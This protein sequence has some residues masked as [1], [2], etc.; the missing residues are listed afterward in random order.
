MSH[1]ILL[2]RK[3]V[4]LGQTACVR[5]ALELI[6]VEFLHSSSPSGACFLPASPSRPT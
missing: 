4:L 5:E 6:S 3:W 2:T 1:E